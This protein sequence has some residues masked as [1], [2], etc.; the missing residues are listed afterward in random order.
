MMTGDVMHGINLDL[1]ITYKHSSLRFFNQGEHHISRI[2]QDDVLLLVYDGV[3]R[4]REDTEA[5]EIHP[6]QYHIQRHNSVQTGEYASDAPKY[7]YVHFIADWAD[8]GC[9]LPCR[10]SFEYVKLKPLIDELDMLSH[11]SASY[12][13]QAQKFYEILIMLYNK[14]PTDSL[15]NKMA[16][17]IAHK[18][19]ERITLEMLCEEFG[20]S[21]N[22]IINL[23]KKTFSMPPV[24]YINHIRLQKAEYLMEVTSD[25]IEEIAGQCGFH[26]YSHFYKLFVRRNRLS[27]DKWR[28]QKRIGIV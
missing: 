8:D 28:E 18:Y 7:L 2:C 23:F 5:F 21:K 10:G 12:T 24:A 13:A 19:S 15:P 3:L 20:F 27:P 4:F 17:Y 1:P 14:K 26:N 9:I 25:S 16:E 22:H 11:S 6:G